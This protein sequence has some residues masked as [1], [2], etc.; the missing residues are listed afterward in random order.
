MVERD[1]IV[2]AGLSHQGMIRK[3]NQDSYGFI[4]PE[5]EELLKRRGRLFIVADGLG[6]HRGGRVASKMAVDIVG[7]LYFTSDK[8][9]IYPALLH[10]LD[11]A[12]RSIFE[13]SSKHEE[14][15][16]M[17][18]TCTALVL[19]PPY[20]YMA[21]VGDSRA[22]LVR[23]GM[24]KQLTT[25]HTLVA[26]MVNSGIINHDEARSH[27]DSHILTRSLGILQ[28]VEIDILEPPLR[29]QPGD[30]LL[31]CSDGLTV[32]LDDQEILQVV[33]G[34]TP[35]KA[36]ETLVETANER[37]GRDN[38]TV[39]LVHIKTP[40]EAPSE[41]AEKTEPLISHTERLLGSPTPAALPV[42]T[43]AQEEREESETYWAV[44]FYAAYLAFMI[45]YFY[46]YFNK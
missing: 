7:K 39:E 4:E 17:A 2:V 6:G 27:P 12:N 22:Y 46:F 31:M 38:V 33:S 20:L 18:T 11:V 3:D 23:N 34:N 40:G 10:A 29:I 30:S 28:A 13:S 35:E 9:P 36:C 16:G 21:H 1:E 42:P 25:D 41:A 19:L 45:L 43:D 37:G 44:L 26:E 5:A 8:D 14:L 32:Y 24:I 15:Q